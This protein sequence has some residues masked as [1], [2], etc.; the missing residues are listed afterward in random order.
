[1]KGLPFDLTLRQRHLRHR[2]SMSQK[3]DT[4]APV[5]EAEIDS[6]L[7]LTRLARP[8]LRQR[9]VTH[10][11]VLET[12]ACHSQI[13]LEAQKLNVTEVRDLPRDKLA[14]RLTSE[15]RIEESWRKTRPR[16]HFPRHPGL[17]T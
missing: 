16:R 3:S 1:M 5:L 15:P 4:L 13:V 10:R 14:L 7:D 6:P 17:R 9:H 11:L 8:P 2:N 12:K